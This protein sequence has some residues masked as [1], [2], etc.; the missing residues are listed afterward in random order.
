MS[1]SEEPKTVPDDEQESIASV[2]TEDIT[3]RLPT[4]QIYMDIPPW[5]VAVCVGCLSAVIMARSQ[6]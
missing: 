6:C 5:L 3:P 2:T 4:I 1:A